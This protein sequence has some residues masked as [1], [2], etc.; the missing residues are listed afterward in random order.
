MN[1]EDLEKWHFELNESACDQ[2]LDLVLK[3]KK[4]ATSSS[5]ASFLNEGT[6]IPEKGDRSVITDWKGNPRCVIETVKV[7]I[8]PYKDIDFDIARL[9][10]EDD[11]LDSWRK[12]HEKFFTEEGKQLGYE[13]SED[14]DVVF[15]EFEVLEIIPLK[16]QPE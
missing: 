3:G 2:L 16:D 13:F 7:R 14:M 6:K 11:D 15:E 1:I 8:I 9:E 10:G 5:V 12:S 4:R